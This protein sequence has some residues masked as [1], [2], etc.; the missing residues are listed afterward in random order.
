MAAVPSVHDLVT[1]PSTLDASADEA[2]LQ[3]LRSRI[4]LVDDHVVYWRETAR[5]VGWQVDIMFAEFAKA[6]STHDAIRWV[7]DVSETEQP[8]PSVLLHFRRL[9]EGFAPRVRHLAIR[10]GTNIG[11]W[12]P[13]RH[14]LPEAG[15]T[16]MTLHRGIETAIA[17]AAR[18]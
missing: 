6:T 10:T 17:R 3:A 12:L 2:L 8:K 13:L 18:V 9:A 1:P 11:I 4:Q 14:V 15:F 7:W 5:M 16:A